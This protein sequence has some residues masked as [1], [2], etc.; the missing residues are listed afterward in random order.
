MDWKFLQT[1]GCDYAQGYFI[2]KP[3]PADQIEPWIPSWESFW[4]EQIKD[5]S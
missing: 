5:K 4:H 1:T 3:M 2:A